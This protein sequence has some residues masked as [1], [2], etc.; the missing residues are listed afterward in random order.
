MRPQRNAGFAAA[1]LAVPG[2][3]SGTVQP[4]APPAG[5]AARN[6]PYADALPVID[7]LRPDL[8]PEPLRG[9]APEAREAAWPGWVERRDREIRARLARGDDDTVVNFLLYGATFTGA[10]RPAPEQVAALARADAPLPDV[11][12]GRIEDFIDAVAV[13][14]RTERVEFARSV[15]LRNGFDPDTPSGR[16]RLRSYLAGEVRRGPAE[17]LQ[18]S[19]SLDD[20]IGRNDPDAA[21]L[22]RTAFR[23]R[24]LSSDT[25]VLVDF[26]IEEALRAAHERGVLRAGG[27]RRAAVVGPGLDFTDKDEGYDIYPVQT[28]QPFAVIDSLLA[29]GLAEAGQLQ[30]T[31]FDLNPRIIRHL[32]QARDRAAAGRPYA[33][34]LPRNLDLAWRGEL[35]AY[36]E[37]LGAAVG[38]PAGDLGVPPSAGNVRVRAV[39]VRPDI[40]LALTAA[41]LNVVLQRLAPLRPDERFDLIVATDILIYYDTFEQS[42]ALMNLA[43]M[44]SPGGLLL[45]NTPVAALPGM[46][47]SAIGHTDA[48]YMPVPGLGDVTDRFTWY[49]RR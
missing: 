6:M 8:L 46:P 41:D 20:A 40:V 43:R 4:E 16:D 21:L 18:I 48:F 7:A 39:H 30:V 37:R 2:V 11:V 45:S 10:P 19:R 9:L 33:L 42:L 24:G 17:T 44:L 5:A 38:A 29:L 34:A 47:L 25:S 1:V 13:G 23:E 12:A 26:G 31:A 32:E 14:S 49:R 36:W 28:V 22:D 35:A 3:L 27:I 15:L